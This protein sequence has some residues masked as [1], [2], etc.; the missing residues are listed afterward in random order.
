MSKTSQVIAS[1]FAI[2]LILLPTFFVLCILFPIMLYDALLL[3]FNDS[4]ETITWI[5]I[6]VLVPLLI[7]PW[8]KRMR[9]AM[10]SAFRRTAKYLFGQKTSEDI[11][12]N[13]QI[14]HFAEVATPVN[15]PLIEPLHI[16]KTLQSFSDTIPENTNNSSSDFICPL[17]SPSLRKMSSSRRYRIDD[18]FS[19]SST[20]TDSTNAV[21]FSN[22]G[23][24]S[25]LFLD[26]SLFQKSVRTGFFHVGGNIRIDPSW[27]LTGLSLKNK[28]ILQMGEIYG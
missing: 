1:I 7:P 26:P 28:P 2:S 16:K 22:F 27:R 18:R 15:E 21:Q 19:S 8:D 11:V 13:D 4:L 10:A 12:F 14:I 23:L 25:T 24:I 9:D 6:A 3:Y 17:P 20:I 5:S